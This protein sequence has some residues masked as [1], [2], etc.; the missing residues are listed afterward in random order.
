MPSLQQ[1]GWL[2]LNVWALFTFALFNVTHSKLA[3]YILPIFP[4]LAVL[5]ALRFFRDT[6][7][8][9]P[10]LPPRWVW[11]LCAVSPLC[12]SAAFPL[13]LPALFRVPIPTWGWWQAGILLAAIILIIALAKIKGVS[14]RAT[15][16]VAAAIPSMLL[17]AGEASLFETDFRAN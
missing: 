16:I 2:L 12:L 7:T 11:V 9:E 4:A 13:A 3:D 14:P 15:L 6:E 10:G 17:I 8:K 5:L 1:D